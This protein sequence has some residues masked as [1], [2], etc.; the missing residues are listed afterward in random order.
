M[1]ILWSPPSQSMAGRSQQR[2]SLSLSA[3]SL[4]LSALSPGPVHLW[5]H[6]AGG[7]HGWPKRDKW[8]SET[9]LLE[10]VTLTDFCVFMA[11]F[12]VLMGSGQSWPI[13][14]EGA[15]ANYWPSVD[16][17]YYLHKLYTFNPCPYYSLVWQV[18]LLRAGKTKCLPKLRS[19][20]ARFSEIKNCLYQIIYF[21]LWRV[22][23]GRALSRHIYQRHRMS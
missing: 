21:L 15:L 16:I 23:R 17:D 11:C 2:G 10:W 7:A 12:R 3:H 19:G 9:A 4:S 20:R 13:G 5:K 18:G 14:R 1:Q 22:W 6:M 8:I